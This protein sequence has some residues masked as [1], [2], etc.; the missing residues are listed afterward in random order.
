MHG[1]LN[2]QRIKM[3][4]NNN[5]G[6]SES[7]DTFLKKNELAGVEPAVVPDPPKPSIDLNAISA[8]QQPKEGTN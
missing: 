7:P 6:K 2:A 5:I 1:N 3:P 8:L 4:E